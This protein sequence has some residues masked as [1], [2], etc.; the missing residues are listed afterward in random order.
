[1]NIKSSGMLAVL[2]LLA[3]GP[4]PAQ[5]NA[6]EP[7]AKSAEHLRIVM[8]GSPFGIAWGFLYGYEGSKP[9]Q[10]MPQLRELGAG[11]TKVYLFWQQLEPTKGNYDWTAVDAYVAQL[12][13]PDEGLIALFS[14]SLW[15]VKKPSAMLPPSPAKNPDDYYRLVFNL[16][17][18]CKGRVRY[19]QNDCEPNDPVYWSGTKEE[20]VAQLKV[21]YRA[22]KDAD[23][24]A[25]VVVGGYDG[26]FGP[27][28]SRAYQFP[29][30]QAS[31]DF[32]DYVFA[33]GRD[34]FD[35]FDLRLYADAY[36]IVARVNYMRKRMHALGFDKPIVCTE[37]GG[38]GFFEFPQNLQY[39]PLINIWMQ[40]VSKTNAQGLPSPDETG[41]KMIASLYTNLP[42]LPPQTQMFL[43]GCSPE[44]EAKYNRIQS[45]SL[46]M[47]NIFAFSAGVQKTLYWELFHDQLERDN[48][49]TL[50][51]GKIALMDFEDGAFKKPYP[52]ANA[53]KIMARSLEGLQAVK[54]INVPGR[55]SIFLF[56]V[57]RGKRGPAYVVWER[58]NEFSGEDAPPVPFA[59]AWT[60]KKATA[61]DALGQTIPVQITDGQMHLDISLTPIFIDA[62]D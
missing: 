27:P 44:L 2:C 15:A 28:G 3:A 24:A 53:Y 49:M 26:L 6:P 22:V 43:L 29:T 60:A 17:K 21:F 8:P 58:R 50:M 61:T 38:P 36:T 19:W 32:F 54:R 12:N 51:Y 18:H 55:P 31:L 23:P 34:A 40:S 59:W 62:A 56:E 25:V 39:V 10:F 37:Y 52:T 5:I 13:S 7:S 1:M 9:A 35:I 57:D 46:V 48:L 16:V 47:R 33:E 14:S 4:A 11:F 42:S 45:R 41:K 20:F 30:Q